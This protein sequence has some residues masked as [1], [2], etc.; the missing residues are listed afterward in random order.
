MKYVPHYSDSGSKEPF[1]SFNL[2]IS[3]PRLYGKEGLE[4]RTLDSQE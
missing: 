4:M 3:L 1:V 2:T